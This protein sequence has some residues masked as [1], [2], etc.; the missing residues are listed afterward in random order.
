MA[1]TVEGRVNI[2]V[3]VDGNATQSL[4]NIYSKFIALQKNVDNLTSSVNENIAESKGN[5]ADYERLLENIITKYKELQSEVTKLSTGDFSGLDTI[6][7]KMTSLQT[8]LAQFQNTEIITSSEVARAQE[9]KE[10][11]TQLMTKITE[12]RNSYNNFKG[13]STL[14]GQ[15]QQSDNISNYIRLLEQSK[16]YT[17]P[18]D[19][20]AIDKLID[21]LKIELEETNKNIEATKSLKDELDKVFSSNKSKEIDFD[22]INFSLDKGQE[23]ID[24]LSDAFNRLEE[25]SKDSSINI[26]DILTELSQSGGKIGK[27]ASLIQKFGTEAGKVAGYAAIL[28]VELKVLKTMWD[29]FNKTVKEAEQDIINVG[30]AVLNL[31]KSLSINAIGGL[32]DLAVNGVKELG[33]AFN[34]LVNDV[35][36]IISALSELSEKGMEVNDA[37]FVMN[38]Y[39]GNEAS[40]QLNTYYEALGQLKGIDITKTEQSL[41]GLFGSLSNM[42]LDSGQMIKYAEAFSGFMNDLSVY[43][44]VDISQVSSQLES[45]ISFGVLNSRSA[46]AR[47]L[48]I[49][50]EMVEQFRELGSVEERAQWILSRWPIFAGKY[51]EWLQ[52][53]QGKVQVLKNTWTNFMNTVGQLALRIYAI[54]APILTNLI[55]LANTVVSAVSRFFGV[56]AAVDTSSINSAS[57]A[58]SGLGDSYEEAGKKAAKSS[59]QVLSFDDVIQINKDSGAG[60]GGAGAGASAGGLSNEL[61]GLLGDLDKNRTKFDEYLEKIK[62]AIEKEQFFEA[63]RIAA[64]ALDYLLTSINWDEVYG[65]IEKYSK[66]LAQFLNG[67]NSNKKLWLDM[68]QTVGKSLNAVSLAIKT[69]F[70]EFSGT[71]F[72]NSLTLMLRSIIDS[73]DE[74]QAADAIYEVLKDIFQIASELIN[75]DLIS[76]VARKLTYLIEDLFKDINNDGGGEKAADALFSFFKQAFV[77]VGNMIV[78][79]TNDEDTKQVVRDFFSTLLQDFADNGQAFAVDL[80]TIIGSMFNFLKENIFT[81]ENIQNFVIGI[82]DFVNQIIE[83]LPSIIESIFT[84]LS[85]NILTEENIQRVVDT[86]HNL[87]TMLSENSEKIGQAMKPVFDAITN[88]IYQLRTDGTLEKINDAI[89]TIIEESGIVDL[90]AEWAGMKLQALGLILWDRIQLWIQERVKLLGENFVTSITSLGQLLLG[91]CITSFVTTPGG[92]LLTE[93]G[94]L[95]IDIASKIRGWWSSIK[96]SFSYIWTQFK[97]WWN[98]NVASIGIKIDVPNWLQSKIG[99]DDID[100]HIPKLATGGIVSSSTIANIGEA[101]PEAVVPLSNSNFI[102]DFAREIAS[103]MNNGTGGVTNNRIIQFDASQFKGLDD[104]IATRLELGNYF[105]G[106]IDLANS[107]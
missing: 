69:F 19:A 50:E 29:T 80:G 96:E 35:Q 79:L 86:I 73:F 28:G 32:R 46:L 64:Q 2:K 72:G 31:T 41:K 78:S 60:T 13:D 52:T 76:D 77:A 18:E 75:S 1:N 14:G 23:N 71:N 70:K 7:S 98:T 89:M 105:K 25:S 83:D 26:N 91:L 10:I 104:S 88:V 6:N 49:T 44:G 47:S 51:D 94:K 56:K 21:K 74:K 3:N 68:G 103:A 36:N 5:Y 84:F 53:D 107:Y 38:N 24:G 8:S 12:T 85:E 63:G 57:S 27:T 40:E 33:D 62:E 61:L 43:Q 45:A 67:F 39:L 16:Q 30:K 90:I 54:V 48:D 20:N 99:I 4:D 37:L 55:N 97:N 92:K 42:N 102:K 81:E 82:T 34:D 101:G 9:L 100:I 22:K 106:C 58:V 59:K 17:R 93:L 95:G 66:G 65:K 11:I 15:M 87:A